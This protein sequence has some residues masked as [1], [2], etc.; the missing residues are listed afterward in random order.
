M[1]SCPKTI[2]HREKSQENFY[3]HKYSRSLQNSCEKKKNMH[4]KKQKFETLCGFARR[5]GLKL[6]WFMTGCSCRFVL[7]SIRNIRPYI[8]QSSTQLLVQAMVISQL[9]Y[10][11]ALLVSLPVCAVKQLQMLQNAAALLVFDQSK[12]TPVTSLLCDLLWPP[13]LGLHPST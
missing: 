1:S 4:G 10:C 2:S 9:D 3:W 12:R 6:T 7:Y 13:I 8:T 11:N 5:D